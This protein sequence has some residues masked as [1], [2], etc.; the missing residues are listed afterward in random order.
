MGEYTV[1]HKFAKIERGG[2]SSVIAGVDDTIAHNGDACVIGVFFLWAELADY[3]CEGDTFEAVVWDICKADDAKFVGAF[4]TL[5]S[6]S[7]Y[8]T[9][10]LA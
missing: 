9:D 8:F 10:A 6:A 2:F 4:D 7:W 1:Y 3:F 5:S